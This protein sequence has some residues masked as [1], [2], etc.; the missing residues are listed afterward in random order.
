MGKNK[1]DFFSETQ[2]MVEVRPTC[3]VVL[4]SVART[5]SITTAFHSRYLQYIRRYVRYF[6]SK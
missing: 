6:V 4:V 3:V 2:C 5:L 1:V